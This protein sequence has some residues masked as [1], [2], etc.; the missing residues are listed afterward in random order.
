[1]LSFEQYYHLKTENDVADAF[2]EKWQKLLGDAAHEAKSMG[3][4]LEQAEA[5]V[6][7][8]YDGSIQPPVPANNMPAP[9]EQPQVPDQ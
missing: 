1:M 3:V 6:R 4:S 7:G 2:S 5:V 9:T 8:V